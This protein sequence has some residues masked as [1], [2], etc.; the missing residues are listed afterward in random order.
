MKRIERQFHYAFCMSITR[1]RVN[2]FH[3][4]I[5]SAWKKVVDIGAKSFQ[6]LSYLI[7][8]SNPILLLFPKDVHY[9]DMNEKETTMEDFEL[10]KTM[11]KASCQYTYTRAKN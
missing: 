2:Q 7:C 3:R 6:F 10:D 11:M 5:S 8:S 9:T 1:K 4:C